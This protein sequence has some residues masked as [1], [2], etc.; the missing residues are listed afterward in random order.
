MPQ[1]P[2]SETRALDSD[3]DTWT[4]PGFADAKAILACREAVV[5][6]AEDLEMEGSDPHLS[7]IARGGR[8]RALWMWGADD[9]RH[10][11]CRRA[12]AAAVGP[13]GGR[14]TTSRRPMYPRMYGG[15]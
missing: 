4:V 15:W 3:R 10:A 11:A 9:D 2:L 8:M 12:M 13:S 6:G 14:Y 7:A 5:L 1:P